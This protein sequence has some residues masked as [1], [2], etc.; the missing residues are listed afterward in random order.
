MTKRSK[1]KYQTSRKDMLLGA[2]QQRADALTGEK[3]HLLG[4]WEAAKKKHG[5]G[6]QKALCVHCGA[7]VIISPQLP[8]ALP[9]RKTAPGM[10]GEALFEQ[11]SAPLLGELVLESQTIQ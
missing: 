8:G 1:Y 9:H 5:V 6:A 2:L 10:K 11:C 7:Q 3:H 4:L